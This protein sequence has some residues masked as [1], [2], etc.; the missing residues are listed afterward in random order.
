[1]R[2]PII[3]RVKRDD[4]RNILFTKGNRFEDMGYKAWTDRS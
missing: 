2:V 4:N 1:M 3:P